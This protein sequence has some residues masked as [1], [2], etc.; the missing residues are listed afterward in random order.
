MLVVPCPSMPSF[1]VCFS[2]LTLFSRGNP[3]APLALGALVRG[4]SRGGPRGPSLAG[5]QH[6]SQP[7]PGWI[8]SQTGARTQTNQTGAR[9]PSGA[10]GAGSSTLRGSGAANQHVIH[11]ET[12][13]TVRDGGFAALRSQPVLTMPQNQTDCLFFRRGTVEAAALRAPKSTKQCGF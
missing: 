10:R 2:L 3:A 1:V 6:W 12:K 4:Q 8:G 11:P 7:R 5:T 13:N 9:T